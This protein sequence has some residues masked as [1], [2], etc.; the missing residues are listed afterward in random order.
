M[1]QIGVEP[2]PAKGIQLPD[3]IECMLGELSD[4]FPVDRTGLPLQR[5]VALEIELEE[6]ANPL[7]KPAFRLSPA[8]MEELKSSWAFCWK[9]DWLDRA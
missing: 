1:S 5:S 2:D 3:V 4:E 6:K 9:R 8:E 7:E